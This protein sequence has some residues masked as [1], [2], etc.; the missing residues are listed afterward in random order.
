MPSLRT[1]HGRRN[2][3]ELDPRR[4]VLYLN[5]A[6]V[7]RVR[8]FP[9]P[10]PPRESDSSGDDAAAGGNGASSSADAC[11][12]EAAAGS[13]RGHHFLLVELQWGV[14]TAA[15][16]VWV[17]VQHDA[18]SG[19]RRCLLLDQEELVRT[20][21]PPALAA[22]APAAAATGGAAASSRR[23]GGR[24]AGVQ[25]AAAAAAAAAAADAAGQSGS[26]AEQPGSYVCSI[27]RAHTDE[28]EPFV[29]P[30][31]APASELVD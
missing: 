13:I 25:Q 24:A 30:L 23:E 17:G 11:G 20:V 28:W 14:V 3:A 7:P 1:G 19:G 4:G 5:A 27:Y 2:M 10:P 9:Y 22:A 12:T 31:P 18:G 8:S 29:L 21:L 16:D 15:R 6:V 26:S